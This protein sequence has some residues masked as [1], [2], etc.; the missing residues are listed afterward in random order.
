MLLNASR[1]SHNVPSVRPR[2]SIHPRS[3]RQRPENINQSHTPGH[4]RGRPRNDCDSVTHVGFD[5]GPFLGDAEHEHEQE[6]LEPQPE[7]DCATGG[8]PRLE[9]QTMERWPGVAKPHEEDGD[10]PGDQDVGRS[11]RHPYPEWCI[12]VR[13][14]A[15]SDEHMGWPRWGISQSAS[16]AAVA[17]VT[18]KPSA[19]LN[20][21]RYSILIESLNSFAAMPWAAR[22]I[23]GPPF[24]FPAAPT[25]VR[26]ASTIL[27]LLPSWWE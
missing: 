1:A 21:R 11:H 27:H 5:K 22:M 17:A 10:R 12:P 25:K 24:A 4:R 26:Q 3:D 23:S 2:R 15:A 20:L 18:I 19:M 13:R 14:E 9:H 8:H 6:R 7:R 16:V